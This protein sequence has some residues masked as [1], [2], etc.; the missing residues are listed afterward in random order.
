METKRGVYLNLTASLQYVCVCIFEPC[1]HTMMLIQILPF[2]D[3]CQVFL[4][5]DKK[6]KEEEEEMQTQVRVKP[7][8]LMR[9]TQGTQFRFS[10]EIK[11]T[12][13][14]DHA[15]FPWKKNKT[16]AMLYDEGV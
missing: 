14:K 15:G 7:I 9:L 16:P 8:Y 2:G 11:E 12:C 6:E 13:F 3:H 5:V 4:S 10:V 1:Y